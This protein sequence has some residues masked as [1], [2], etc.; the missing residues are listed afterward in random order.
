MTG[1]H[2]HSIVTPC[3]PAFNSDAKLWSV[4][5]QQA[6]TFSPQI[7]P[8]HVDRVPAGGD[9]DT[10]TART[11]SLMAEYIRQ[12]LTDPLIYRCARYA[13][14]RFGAGIDTDAAKCWAVFWYVKHCV[15]FK[16]DEGVMIALG[17]PGEQDVLIS[18]SVLA[19]MNKPAEDCDGFTMFGC[20]LLAALGI[21]VAMV[22]VAV[23]PQAPEVWSHV[24]PVAICAGGIQPLDMSHGPKPGWMVPASRISRWQAF[25]LSGRPIDLPRPQTLQPLHGF[26]AAPVRIAVPR[27]RRM[28]RRGMGDLVCDET[29]VCTDSGSYA[30]VSGG[31]YDPGTT[32]TGPLP[33][34]NSVPLTTSGPTGSGPTSVALSCPQNYYLSANGCQPVAPYTPSYGVTQPSAA[35]SSASGSASSQN[36]LSSLVSGSFGLATKVLAPVSTTCNTQTGVCSTTGG[37][38]ILPASL[39]GGLNSSYLLVGA[40]VFGIFLV[41]GKK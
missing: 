4:I 9:V 18:P 17:S 1:K 13:F 35:G 26:G 25:D 22:A 29:G 21:P 30:P 7:R 2:V 32:M 41:M 11:I 34:L 12:A 38:G 36:W 14:E 6:R 31:T 28:R 20:A 39:T 37:S 24:F 3:L 23:N 8:L 40:L 27:L 33:S 19:R 5:A 10:A 15:K 16:K